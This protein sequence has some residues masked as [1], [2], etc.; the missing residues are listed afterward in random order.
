MYR[1]YYDNERILRIGMYLC[2]MPKLYAL[3]FSAYNYK[4][5]YFFLD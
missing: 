4:I 5:K 2:V 1:M 3:K